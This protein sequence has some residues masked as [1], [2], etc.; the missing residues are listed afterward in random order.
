[1]AKKNPYVMTIGFKKDDSDYL[2]V[3]DFL[4]GMGRGKAQY[5][6]KA[7]LIYQ[8]VQLNG[9]ASLRDMTVM[10][11]NTIKEMVIQILDEREG[12]KGHGSSAKKKDIE[13]KC[14]HQICWKDLMRML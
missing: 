11:Y 5:I 3:A 12:A 10:D 13:K 9:K 4:N 8:N 14:K 6:V 1:M 7:I 2:A